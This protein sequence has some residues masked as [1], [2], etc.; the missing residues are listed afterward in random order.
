MGVI[1]TAYVLT[2]NQI[3]KIR[4]DHEA[5]GDII[6]SENAVRYDFDTI[7]EAWVSIFHAC[8]FTKTAKNI[9]SEQFELGQIEYDSYDIWVVPPK[10]VQAMVQELQPAKFEL[11]KSTGMAAGT[12]DKRGSLLLEAEY[13]SYFGDI[14]EL[15]DFLQKAADQGHYLLFTEA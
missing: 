5:L 10:Q 9:D 14:Q 4:K 7:I 8:G 15:K 6:E 1:T 11:L 2:P 3:K 12:T 13:S